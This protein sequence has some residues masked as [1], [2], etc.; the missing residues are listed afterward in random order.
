MLNTTVDTLSFPF[1]K[2]IYRKNKEK[3][4]PVLRLFIYCHHAVIEICGPSLWCTWE[5]TEINQVGPEE[6]Q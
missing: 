6:H 2:S 5:S 3:R 4:E 1:P